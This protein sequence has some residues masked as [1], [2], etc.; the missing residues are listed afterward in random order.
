MGLLLFIPT[1]YCR[2]I[3]SNTFPSYDFHL[4]QWYCLLHRK[5]DDFPVGRIFGNVGLD[6]LVVLSFLVPIH[7]TNLAHVYSGEVYL[8]NVTVYE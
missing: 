2:P 4:V 8:G 3:G 6:V 1:Y 5:I 7:K